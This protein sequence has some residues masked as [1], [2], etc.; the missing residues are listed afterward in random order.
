MNLRSML[1]VLTLTIS[2]V[3]L[4]ASPALAAEKSPKKF[5][6]QAGGATSKCL[7][8][9]EDARD[10]VKDANKADRKK[11]GDKKAKG[12]AGKFCKANGAGPGS[13]A[14]KKC[15]K[16]A[17]KAEK[18]AGGGGNGGGGEGGGGNGGGGGGG[19]NTGQCADGLDNDGDGKVDTADPDCTSA[20]DPLEGDTYV[21]PD[22]YV[23]SGS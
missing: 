12:D 13:K 21:P 8:L 10:A 4:G 19:G 14:F 7:S 3:A 23:P 9:A 15:E 6:K 5:C 17:K 16:K 18:A 11:K 20:T 1:L 2:M 22:D